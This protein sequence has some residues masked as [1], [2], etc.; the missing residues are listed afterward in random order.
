MAFLQRWRAEEKQLIWFGNAEGPRRL[1]ELEISLEIERLAC[2]TRVP[3]RLEVIEI[4]ITNFLKK[5]I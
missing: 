3:G 5:L 2:K 4:S 1:R